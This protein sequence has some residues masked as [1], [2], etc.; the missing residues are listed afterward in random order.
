MHATPTRL[1]PGGVLDRGDHGLHLQVS[2][3]AV[4]A[5]L[6]PDATLL[7]PAEGDAGVEDVEAVHPDGTG[8]ERT[9]QGVGS[10]QALGEHT[11][12]QSIWACICPRDNLIQIPVEAGQKVII[13]PI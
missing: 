4:D 12:G 1:Q 2:L 9:C 10:V 7:V 13:R 6:P 3:E 8:P 11:G 5:L